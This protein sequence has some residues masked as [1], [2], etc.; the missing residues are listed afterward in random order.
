MLLDSN[1]IIYSFQKKH[2][3]LRV[4]MYG[5]DTCCSAISRVETLGYPYLS[6]NEKLYLEEC[7]GIITVFPISQ[8]VIDNAV[9]LR[10]QRKMS[11]GDSIVAATA[12]QYRQTLVTR[13]VK[14]FLIRKIPQLDVTTLPG[15]AR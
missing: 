4:F 12:L 14:D 8:I 15:E 13:N 2:Q 9:I 5:Q 7:F 1:I 3:F 11:L 10:Q 6:A